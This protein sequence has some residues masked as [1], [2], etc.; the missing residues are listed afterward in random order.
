MLGHTDGAHMCT[1]HT[2]HINTALTHKIHMP[3]TQ[4][5]THTRHPH[6]HTED[7]HAYIQTHKAHMSAHMDTDMKV[8]IH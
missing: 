3:A 4:M 8:F 2:A 7:M 1:Q 5:H 6:V